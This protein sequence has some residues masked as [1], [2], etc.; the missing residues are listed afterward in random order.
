MLL[1]N[2]LAMPAFQ[3]W[4][5]GHPFDIRSLLTTPD[6][7]PRH[8]VFYIAHLTDTERMFFVTLLFTAVETWM[9]SQTGTSSLRALV[10]FDEIYGYL[11][12]VRNPPS[13][14]PVLRMLKQ[15]P[16][17]S[18]VGARY[19]KSCG[20]RL[21]GPLECRYAGGCAPRA[22]GPFRR[23]ATPA[24]LCLGF[25]CLAARSPP[26]CG[27]VFQ[28]FD[29]SGLSA[30]QISRGSSLPPPS[31]PAS[32]AFSGLASRP[33][34]PPSLPSGELFLSGRSPRCR[35]VASLTQYIASRLPTSGI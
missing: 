8:S 27:K 13:K 19:P 35:R 10:Y 34:F 9:R 25:A 3:T 32:P 26:P 16:R 31:L 6:G 15:A 30:F 29:P 1:N 24:P 20:Y 28:A 17:W 22:P 5:E 12:P 14:Q 21:Q 33:L 2:I 7:R 18:R 4:I 23:L 11:P